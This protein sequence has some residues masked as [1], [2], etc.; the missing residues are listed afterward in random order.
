MWS[1]DEVSHGEQSVDAASPPRQRRS[2]PAATGAE[3]RCR[4]LSRRPRALD[5]RR[6]A[7][8]P[9]SSTTD[10]LHRGPDRRDHRDGRCPGD[11]CD[12]RRQRRIG[13]VTPQRTGTRAPEDAQ[14]G[15]DRC[16]P[17]G[18][19]QRVVVKHARLGVGVDVPQQHPR[20]VDVVPAGRPRAKSGSM[21]VFDDGTSSATRRRLPRMRSPPM[22]ATRGRV[23][24]VPIY[25]GERS[26]GH[27]TAV[28]GV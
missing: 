12:A 27:P 8:P 21:T 26:R 3:M 18:G 16:D 20:R 11:L 25:A 22:F 13:R 10:G 28:A 23:S 5:G 24:R 2:T 9:R 6:R 1:T 7:S 15:I 19:R 4:G 17:L 14:V